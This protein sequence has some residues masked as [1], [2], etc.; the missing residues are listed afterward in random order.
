MKNNSQILLVS[1]Y[2]K[3]AEYFNNLR[4]NKSLKFDKEQPL[5]S[6]ITISKN[7]PENIK[8]TLK[9]VADQDY[10]YIEHIIIN[11]GKQIELELAEN[12]LLLNE[13][14]AG[15][16]DAFNKGVVA[17]VGDIICILNAGDTYPNTAITKVVDQFK[18][19]P[20]LEI[21]CASAAF[22]DFEDQVFLRKSAHKKLNLYMS[23]VHPATFVLKKVYQEIGLFDLTYDL[24]MDYEFLLRARNNQIKFKSVDE[25]LVSFYSGGQSDRRWRQAFA[26]SLRA[27]KFYHELDFKSLIY[28]LYNFLYQFIYYTLRKLRLFFLIKL[29]RNLFPGLSY[30]K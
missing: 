30:Y 23:V 21:L 27:R 20:K 25:V 9:S 8:R 5:V 3:T 18:Q 26:E 11:G 1:D 14:D 15:I 19:N 12:V 10:K 4:A 17:A 2:S 16:S 6:I 29:F 22:Q 13:P 7:D 24:A 28:D